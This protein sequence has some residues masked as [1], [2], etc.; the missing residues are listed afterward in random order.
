MKKVFSSPWTLRVLY[1]AAS[2]VT[3]WQAKRIWDEIFASKRDLFDLFSY[4]GTVATLIGLM[5]TVC[6]VLHSAHMSRSVRNE[7]RRLLGGLQA[8]D[9]A[10]FCAECISDIQSI[11]ES[12]SKDKYSEALKS[13]NYLSRAVSHAR[14]QSPKSLEAWDLNKI[15]NLLLPLQK[16]TPRKPPSHTQ[17]EDL[18]NAITELKDNIENLKGTTR[19]THVSS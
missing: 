11:L 16:A 8:F 6:E 12:I 15:L 9:G 4:I 10:T 14:N 2:L 1:I 13:F 3:A 5:I 17:K 7:A 18:T 19:S